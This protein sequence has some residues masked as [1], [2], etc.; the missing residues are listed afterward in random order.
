MPGGLRRLRIVQ[1]G[2]RALL[3][4]PEMQ[5][6]VRRAADAIAGRVRA[7]GSPTYGSL[8][9]QVSVRPRG[10]VKGDRAQADVVVPPP[11]AERVRY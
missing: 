7:A 9:P 2:V 5:Q 11:P 8:N 4:G 3:N 1:P 10:G 6:A